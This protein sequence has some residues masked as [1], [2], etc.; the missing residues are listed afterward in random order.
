MDNWTNTIN[1]T[2]QFKSYRLSL[3]NGNKFVDEINKILQIVSYYLIRSIQW[4]MIEEN[5]ITNELSVCW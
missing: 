2:L 1:E 5:P 3:H 4:K